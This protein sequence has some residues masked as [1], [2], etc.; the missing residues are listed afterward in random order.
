MH[1]DLTHDPRWLLV[2]R[3]AISPQFQ[4]TARLRD[5]LTYVAVE[6]LQ[7]RT[8]ELSEHH[9]GC[10]VFERRP[11]YSPADDNIVRVHAR[12]LRLRLEEYFLT[13]GRDEPLVVEIP[14]GSVTAQV[15]PPWQDVS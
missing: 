11:G 9:I 12:Q 10:G 15:G 3:I 8:G 2:Q 1:A 6:A 7:G 13:N 5:F 4:K 14:K